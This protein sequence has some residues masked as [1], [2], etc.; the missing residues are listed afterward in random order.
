[1]VKILFIAYYFPP[2]GGGGVPRAQKFARY[3]P[4]EGF[5][6]IVLAGPGAGGDRWQ[7]TDSTRLADIPPTVK[8][9]RVRGPVPAPS[10][11][12][13]RRIEGLLA[14]PD[15]FS[16]WWVSSAAKLGTEVAEDASFIL[17]TMPPFHSAEVADAIS[18]RLGIPWVADLRDPWA[19]DEIQVYPTA[20]QRRWEQNKM[21]R[22]LSGAEIIVMN[23]SDAAKALV[24]AIPQLDGKKIL[25]IHNGFD[26]E[27]FEREVLLRLD[28]KF[29][30]VHAG[31]MLTD[32]GLRLR[33][34][35]LHHLLGGAVSGI[36]VLTRSPKILMEA[37]ERWH[38]RRP[39]VGADLEMLFI[40]QASDAD[41]AIVENSSI[42]KCV[43]LAGYLSHVETLQFIRTADLL[44]LPMHN[45]SGGR[46]STTAPGKT[47]EYMASGRPILAAV[48][49]G[50]AR[51]FLTQCGTAHICRPDDIGGMIGILDR[52]YD[53]WKAGEPIPH[54]N[55]E[56][57]NTFE[58]RVLTRELATAFRTYVLPKLPRVEALA[59][60]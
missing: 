6:P 35:R 20:L 34:Q 24:E 32:A 21:A 23:T 49:D 29:R 22:L 47:F 15:T 39:A 50:D 18:Q 54:L 57:C 59:K 28:A 27:D 11:K 30:V 53:A 9:H 3:L 19:V 60:I 4:S 58:R 2:D 46:R 12:W 17:A 13:R 56:H 1:M 14:Q 40:G 37:L 38:Q 48:P 16:K 33:G 31:A 42:S 26:K 25:T 51:D 41:R 52:V 8:V 5:T 45:L 43:R 44:F 55:R 7:P 10:P 36:D